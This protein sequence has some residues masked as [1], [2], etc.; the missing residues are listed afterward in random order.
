MSLHTDFQLQNISSVKTQ[1]I[2]FYILQSPVG[3]LYELSSSQQKYLHCIFPCIFPFCKSS[4]E[5]FRHVHR[6]RLHYFQDKIIM[7]N[8]KMSFH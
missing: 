8:H 7:G 5:T 4:D 1:F 3:F 2:L 6:R